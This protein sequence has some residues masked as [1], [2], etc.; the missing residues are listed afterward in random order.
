MMNGGLA[1]LPKKIT[2]INE[3]TD[4]FKIIGK[5]YMGR[6]GIISNN[7]LKD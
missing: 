3:D 4:N 7:K 5:V 6:Q 1:M 2:F